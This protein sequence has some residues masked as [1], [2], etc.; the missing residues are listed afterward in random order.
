MQQIERESPTPY[1]EQLY[2]ILRGQVESG[3]FPVDERLPSELEL[4][5]DFGLSRATVRQT[6]QKL[7]T[8]GW[9]R[10]VMRRGVFAARPAES[11]GWFVQDSQG[12]LESQVRQGQ[13][14]ITTEVVS[15]GTVAP[16]EHVAQA[17]QVAPGDEVFAL[18]RVRSRDGRVA[19]FSTNWFPAAVGETISAAG[20]V[21]DGTGS[22]NQTLRE[23]GWVTAGAR[24]VVEALR[25]GP[26]VAAALGVADDE[27]ALR[28]RSSSWGAD[29]V[30]F[31]Y[32]ETWVLTDVIPLEV[33]VTAS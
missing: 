9:A 21:L 5:R 16:P 23:N 28:V 4:C 30:R 33:N 13:R 2:R 7:E 3:E 26:H 17:L 32:Y 11:T 22:V 19:M 8:D 31:D 24:R 18:E 29:G 12:F 25:A 1:Y 6:L 20:D 27:P 15:A 10:R 14:G